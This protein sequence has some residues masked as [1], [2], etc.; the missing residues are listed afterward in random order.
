MQLQYAKDPKWANAE[1]TL[2][3]LTVKW[4]AIDEELPFTASPNDSEEHG[5]SLFAAAQAGEFGPIAEYVAP[6]PAPPVIPE[7]VTRAQGKVVLI[8]TGLWQPVLDY[9][10]GIA[11]PMQKALAEVALHDAQFWQRNSSLLNQAAEVLGITQEQMDQLFI[12][13]SEIAL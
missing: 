10:A 6:P 13:A 3:D 1:Q 9:V 2:I 4:D 7:K 5:C 8:R 11:D 12:Q